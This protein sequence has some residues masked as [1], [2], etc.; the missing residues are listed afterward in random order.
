MAL[1]A[2]GIVATAIL[3]GGAVLGVL[4]MQKLGRSLYDHAYVDTNLISDIRVGFERQRG[5]VGRAPAEFDLERMAEQKA[6]F[7]DTGIAVRGAVDSYLEQSGGTAMASLVTEFLDRLAAYEAEA[8]GVYESAENF[9]SDNAIELVSGPVAAA[10]AAVERSL[11]AMS[12]QVTTAARN[13]V[14]AMETGSALV[15]RAVL[16]VTTVL[17]LA[18]GF[19]GFVIITRSVSRPIGRLSQAMQELGD[20]DKSIDI[21]FTDRQDEIGSMARPLMVFKDNMIRAN[22]LAALQQAEQAK[23]EARAQTIEKISRDFDGEVRDLLKSVSDATTDLDTAARSMLKVSEETTRQS[24]SVANA[25]TQATASVQTVASA[26]EELSSSIREIGSQVDESTRIARE[27]AEQAEASS[28]AVNELETSAQEI[29]KIINLIQDIA[30]QTNLLALNATIEAARAGE[31]GKGFAVVASE[32]KS[33]ATQTGKATEEI[34][35]QIERIQQETGR[36]AEAI[37]KISDTVSRLSE[38]STGIASAVEEQ[39]TATQ[40]IGRSVQDAASGTHE[41]SSNISRV[42][43]GAKETSTSA[44]RVQATSGKLGQHSETLTGVISSFLDS[45]RAA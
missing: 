15:R 39:S 40:E 43:A 4:E 1:L 3:G 23:R 37:R 25:S 13:N 12:E 24:A 21:P 10:A 14:G 18:L 44:N 22:K 34:S 7:E 26:T 28:Q 38:I 45:V 35:S 8:F 33:L 2:G 11:T 17:A 31:S 29:G 30:E 5:L 27:A 20:G 42:N 41:V 32:V 16:A 36:S 9:D 19:G 6:L